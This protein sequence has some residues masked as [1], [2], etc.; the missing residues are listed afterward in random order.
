MS[1]MNNHKV[2]CK[3]AI[4]NH[5]GIYE[6]ATHVTRISSIL[7][8]DI[9]FVIIAAFYWQ[10]TMIGN[11]YYFIPST[12]AS[13]TDVE[14]GGIEDFPD[15]PATALGNEFVEVDLGNGTVSVL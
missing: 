13:S 3:V 1:A 14:L 10:C 2:T 11:E 5:P 4:L 12:Q 15:K 9:I 7:Y 6:V 8:D